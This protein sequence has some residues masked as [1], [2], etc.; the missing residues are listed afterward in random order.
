MNS[1]ASNLPDSTGRQFTSSFSSQSGSIPGFHHSGLHNMHGN[2][3]LPNMAGSLAQRNAGISGLPSSGVQQAGGGMP[4]RF[5]SNN[6]PVAMSQIPHAHSGV[7][8]RGMNVG[9][10]PA[11]SSS[12]NIG[13][14]IQ[15][16]SSNLG[17]GGS[18]NSVPGMSV[19][20]GLGNLGPRITGSV[21]NMVG[22]SNIGRNISSGGLSVPSIASRMN[23]SGNA[24]SGNLNVQG[25]NRM[26][27]GLLQQGT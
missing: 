17:S 11:F 8:G 26:M 12:M 14:T 16:L 6:L 25:S 13:G 4:G 21:G 27:N 2:Y 1:S 18:R 3:N 22:G 7:G 10:G 5:A 15:G 20:P 23:L 9:A 19:S 24:G